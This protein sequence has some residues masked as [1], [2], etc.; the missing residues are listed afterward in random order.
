MTSMD[1]CTVN[2]SK[3]TELCVLTHFRFLIILFLFSK[4]K[5]FRRDGREIYVKLQLSE[6]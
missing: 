6:N 4:T 5:P 1:V 2:T 3:E